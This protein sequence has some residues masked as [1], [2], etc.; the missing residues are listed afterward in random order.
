MAIPIKPAARDPHKESLSRTEIDSLLAV[1]RDAP[2]DEAPAAQRLQH[3]LSC[4]QS[5]RT[6]EHQFTIHPE[7]LR[8]HL[9]ELKLLR[10]LNDA[11]R[12]K[13]AAPLADEFAAV[14]RRASELES[15]T[16]ALREA[17]IRLCSH[18]GLGCI[19][20]SEAIVNARTRPSLEIPRSGDPERTTLEQRLRSLNLWDSVAS[21]YAPRL[22]KLLHDR[23]DDPS[24][25][26]LRALCPQ[27]TTWEFRVE[28]R[29]R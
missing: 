7:S 11:R 2:P 28:R 15:R 16:A 9:A 6:L 24:L 27:R 29:T 21:L 18:T 8:P 1:L 25:A 10:T 19:E 17:L 12:A 5:F 26:E 23:A 20:G 13:L 22:A 14:K 3:L 4:D